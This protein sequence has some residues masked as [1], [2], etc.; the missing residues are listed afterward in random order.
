[1]DSIKI[2]R[3]TQWTEIKEEARRNKE[4]IRNIKIREIR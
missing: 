1:M 3:I 4:K 2:I